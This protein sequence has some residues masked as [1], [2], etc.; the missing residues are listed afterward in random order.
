M[1]TKFIIGK[2]M[3]A[4]IRIYQLVIIPLMP[5]CSCRFQ[6]TCSH[7]AMEAITVYGPFQGSWLAIKRIL[8]CNP[9]GGSGVDEVP[10]IKHLT[11]NT[12]KNTTG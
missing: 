9:W 12:I 3:Q 1:I 7:Y 6:P 4:A 8:S 5:T 2:F 10:P 11:I